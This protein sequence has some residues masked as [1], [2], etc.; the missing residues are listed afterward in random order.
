TD[1]MNPKLCPDTLYRKAIKGC[2]NRNS[3]ILLLHCT[4][5]QKNTCKALPEI[6]K[7]YKSK[8]YEFRVITEDTPELFFHMKGKAFK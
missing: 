8:G 3:I 2:E 5:M 6:I 1:G 4:D 7:Y